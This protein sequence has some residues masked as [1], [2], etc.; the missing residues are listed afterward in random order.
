MP[1]P[2]LR[3][4]ILRMVWICIAL[5]LAAAVLVMLGQRSMIYHPTVADDRALLALAKNDGFEPWLNSGGQRIGWHRRASTQP[6]PGR[7]IVVHGNAG[8]A[9]HRADYAMALQAASGF[10]AFLLEYPGYGA[11]PGKP[12]QASFYAA[13]EEAFAVLRTNG[14]VHLVGESL[15][16]GVA[17]HIAGAHPTEIAGMLLFTP[18][19]NLTA[20]AQHHMPVV[21]VR[22]MLWDRYPA[23]ESLQG[24]RG[25]VGILLAGNDQVV[26]DRFGR[27][28]HDGYPGPKKLWE[29]PQAGHNDVH[30]QPAE[31]WR[32]VVEFWASS[33]LPSAGK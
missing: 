10:D 12:S 14:P 17:A 23:D 2:T 4:R 25:P 15:G 6:A 11:R 8:F 26:P 5:Y 1:A 27:R 33:R 19:N 24:Y 7:F 29:A 32:A 31:W 9:L 3:R 18:Y 13:M 21:P 22:W 20:V 16:C 30:R 28:L